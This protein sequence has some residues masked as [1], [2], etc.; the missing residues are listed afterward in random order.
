MLLIGGDRPDA[1]ALRRPAADGRRSSSTST[2]RSARAGRGSRRPTPTSRA[3]RGLWLINGTAAAQQHEPRGDGRLPG[4]DPRDR[5]RRQR[6]GAR[7]RSRSCRPTTRATAAGASSTRRSSIRPTSRASASTASI[8]SM[9]P[10][11]QTSDRLMAE[12][13][14][15]PDR[16]AGAYAWRSIHAAGAPLAF[17]SDAPVESARS[18]SPGWPSAISREDAKGEPFGGWHPQR[19]GHPRAGARRLHR[20]RGLRR[21]R[22]G[23]VRPLV[24]GRG[25]LPRPRPRHLRRADRARSARR[26]CS[27]PGSPGARSGNGATPR[28]RAPRAAAPKSGASPSPRCT[29]R[30]PAQSLDRHPQR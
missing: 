19:D 2:A 25:R 18:R 12:A 5:R 6:R 15:G 22:R 24:P 16:L 23:P 26:R 4:R 20:R 1:V 29:A 14:L 11:H 3:T 17:G 9:Q 10:V 28:G 8:A 13:R 7:A 21:L 30:R 27:R